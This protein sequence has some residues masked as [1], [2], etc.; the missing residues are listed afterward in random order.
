MYHIFLIYSLVEGRL[1]CF[2]VLAITNNMAMSIVEQMFF[3]YDWASYGYIPKSSIAGSWGRLI[4]NILRTLHTD[5]QRD[6]ISLYSHQQCRSVS[7]TSH[8]LQHKLSVVLILTILTGIRWNLRVV[9]ICIILMMKNV[10]HLF[11]CL[12]A[13]RDSSIESFLF[14]AISHLFCSVRTRRKAVS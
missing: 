3:W 10:E 11:M 9:L 7:L 4:T 8:P 12:S 5:F 1:G 13:I 6:C 2:Q 14:R